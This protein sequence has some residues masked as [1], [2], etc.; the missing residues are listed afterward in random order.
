MSGLNPRIV[1]VSKNLHDEKEFQGKRYGWQDAAIYNGGDFPAPF[2]VNVQVGHEYE[3][4]EYVVDP[5][6]FR[7][8][9]NK[10]LR[11]K[12]VKLLPIGGGKLA[13]K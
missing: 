10:N 13:G 5:R 11:L 2:H 8:D 12:S 1:V 7:P 4:G 9:D 3:P 6:S